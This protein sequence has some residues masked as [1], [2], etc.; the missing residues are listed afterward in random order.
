[1]WCRPNRVP[2]APYQTPYRVSA[3]DGSHMV[4][5]NFGAVSGRAT[6]NVEFRMWDS[7]LDTGVIQSSHRSAV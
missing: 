2:A 1:M 6:D 3:S 7:T 5:L 4:G